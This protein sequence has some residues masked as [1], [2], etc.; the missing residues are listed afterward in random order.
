MNSRSFL[1]LLALATPLSAQSSRD[2]GAIRTIVENE[3]VT[4]N[5]GDAVGYS[6]DFARD[7]VAALGRL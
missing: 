2:E 3:T 1:L 5:K 6:R 7:G 4:W